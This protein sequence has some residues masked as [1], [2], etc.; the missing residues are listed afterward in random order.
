MIRFTDEQEADLRRLTTEWRTARI[1]AANT[2]AVAD[3][4]TQGDLAETIAEIVA[5][6]FGVDE[7]VNQPMDP[8]AAHAHDFG[9]PE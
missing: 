8:P 5:G 7:V 3:W 4:H 1:T 6:I 9:A 2:D